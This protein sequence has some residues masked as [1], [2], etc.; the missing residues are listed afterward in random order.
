MNSIQ[1]EIDKSNKR[2][3]FYGRVFNVCMTVIIVSNLFVAMVYFCKWIGV[4]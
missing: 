3:K 1:I 2:F 4:L